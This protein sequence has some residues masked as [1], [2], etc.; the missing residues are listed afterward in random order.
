MFILN[1]PS[2]QSALHSLTTLHERIICIL[3]N[4][5]QV[6]AHIGTIQLWL[7]PEAYTGQLLGI[8]N[9]L[10]LPVR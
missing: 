4:F 10:L 7:T 8:H 3:F 5:I 1:M 9:Y 6:W 2:L